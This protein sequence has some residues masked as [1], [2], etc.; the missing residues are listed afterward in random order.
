MWPNIGGVARTT[1]TLAAADPADKAR[2]Y[3]EMGIDIIY[4]QDG[5]VV[6]ESRP[7]LAESS[8]GERTRHQSFGRIPC[9]LCSRHGRSLGLEGSRL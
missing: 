8:V 1:A 2:V 5:R 7:R 4:H 6:V 3:A 9:L